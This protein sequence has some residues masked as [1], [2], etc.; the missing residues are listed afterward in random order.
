MVETVMRRRLEQGFAACLLLACAPIFAVLTIL[1]W[2]IQRRP[3]FERVWVRAAG[4]EVWQFR[5]QIESALG[6]WMR[7]WLI[8]RWPAMWNVV[9]ADVDLQLLREVFL[10]PHR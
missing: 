9:R 6:R 3:I 4:C 10:N 7:Q 1:L 8:D 2:T 5:T